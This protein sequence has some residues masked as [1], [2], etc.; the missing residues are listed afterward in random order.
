M[1]GMFTPLDMTDHEESHVG[2]N[3]IG[4]DLP[5]TRQ[6]WLEDYQEEKHPQSDQLM[7]IETVEKR[8]LRYTGSTY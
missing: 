2:W 5:I 7:G 8:P 4:D 6:S 1:N 3:E